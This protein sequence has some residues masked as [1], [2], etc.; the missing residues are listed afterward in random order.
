M[1]YFVHPLYVVEPGT[2]KTEPLLEFCT[3]TERFLRMLSND[4]R[5]DLLYTVEICL[6]P[7]WWSPGLYLCTEVCNHVLADRELFQRP[8]RAELHDCNAI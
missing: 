1:W 7:F 5:E 8:K 4:G 3:L 6:E 2:S